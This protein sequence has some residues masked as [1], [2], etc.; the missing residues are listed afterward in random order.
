MCDT[1]N[2]EPD[3]KK[4]P[5]D[6]E[7]L[8]WHGQLAVSIFNLLTDTINYETGQYLGKIISG[9]SELFDIFEINDTEDKK[10]ILLLVKILDIENTSK[11]MVETKARLE[12]LKH[13]K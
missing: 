4:I 8:T 1:M 11:S 3:P 13:G 2:I 10:L 5:I 12:A 6:I 9:I 7:D